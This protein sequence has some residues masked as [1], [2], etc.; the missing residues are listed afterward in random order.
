MSIEAKEESAS[1]KNRGGE[2]E[3]LWEWNQEKN[4][5]ILHASFSVESRF[6]HTHMAW[7]QKWDCLGK[8]GTSCME[9]GGEKL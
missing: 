3:G 6:K 4:I 9:E 8:E 5:K 1:K 7:R 2:I